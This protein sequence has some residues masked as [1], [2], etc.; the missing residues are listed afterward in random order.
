MRSDSI[1]HVHALPTIIQSQ[2]NYI[3]LGHAESST[4][5]KYIWGAHLF[6]V[7]TRPTSLLDFFSHA[8]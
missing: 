6:Q 3:L 4:K 7:L 1:D 8:S 5:K 2:L